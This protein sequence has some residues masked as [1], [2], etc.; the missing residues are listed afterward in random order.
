MFKFAHLGAIYN[1]SGNNPLSIVFASGRAFP[2]WNTKPGDDK[3]L[4]LS[5]HGLTEQIGTPT[6]ANPVPMRSVGDTG[7]LLS[8]MPD[9]AG[10]DYQLLNI[11]EA[12]KKAGHD[13]ILRSVNGIYDEVVYDGKEWKLIQRIQNDRIITCTGV[14]N[15]QEVGF[16]DCYF[17]PTKAPINGSTP[18][19]LLSTHFVQGNNGVG[20]INLNNNSPYLGIFRYPTTVNMTKEEITAWLGENEVYVSY[21]LAE[22][23]EYPLDLP[24]I[25]TYDEQTY[26]ASNAADVKPRMVAQCQVSKALDYIREGLIGYYTGRGRSNDDENKNIL[27]DLSGN[28]N[29]LENKNFAYTPDSGYGDGYIQ[30]DGVDDY[31]NG[32]RFENVKRHIHF[33]CSDYKNNIVQNT[34]WSG[35]TSVA[36][37]IIRLYYGSKYMEIFSVNHNDSWLNG[38]KYTNDNRIGPTDMISAWSTNAYVPEFNLDLCSLGHRFFA[39]ARIHDVLMYDRYLTEEEVQHNYKVSCQYN[40]ED[41]DG[42]AEE[43]TASGENGFTVYNSLPGIFEELT[44]YGKS[45]QDGTP[46]PAN[47]IPINSIGDTPLILTISNGTET[48]QINFGDIKLRSVG[49]VS[50]ELVFDNSIG[51]WKLIQRIGSETLSEAINM[52]SSGYSW[53]TYSSIYDYKLNLENGKYG[54]LFASNKFVA[55]SGIGGVKNSVGLYSIPT[56]ICATADKIYETIEECAAYIGT[57]DIIGVLAEPIETELDFESP[58]TF[59][60]DVTVT[61]NQETVLPYMTAR[62]EVGEKLTLPA[63]PLA[64]Y[65][66]GKQTT[67]EMVFKDQSGNGNDIP[68]FNIA[69]SAESGFFQGALRLDG[70]DDTGR[71]PLE[72]FNPV[73]TAETSFFFSG[74]INKNYGALNTLKDNKDEQIESASTVFINETGKAICYY[75]IDRISEDN[76]NILGTPTIIYVMPS[77][78]ALDILL[79]EENNTYFTLS[80]MYFGNRLQDLTEFDY[81]YLIIYPRNLTPEEQ[82]IV[83]KYIKQ[84]IYE[85]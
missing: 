47:P 45:I 58:K 55:S 49:T 83:L 35:M 62:A 78:Q 85:L 19:G 41:I 28:G 21:Q 30:Y 75:P 12:M 60:G 5:I 40:G 42:K 73:I 18:N 63:D 77:L 4:S 26:F 66:A 14:S 48:Q 13:G 70:V 53:C 22:P 32:K 51:K 9:K 10:S 80:G 74:S 23:A 71:L 67:G 25:T 20:T 81:R 34:I 59:S 29:D 8:V 61:T 31:S 15:H 6:P 72:S 79:S 3:L 7:M 69:H 27:P 56:N 1:G 2:I 52:Y 33:V 76:V 50:D 57:F 68:L 11:K 37:K 84:G 17:Y 65:I 24:V 82:A 36:S 39:K 64:I 46:T 43:T 54:D 16:T 38:D 44:V